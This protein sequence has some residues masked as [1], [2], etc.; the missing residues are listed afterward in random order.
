MWSAFILGLAGSLHC[1]GMCGPL[2]LALPLGQAGKIRS[3]LIYHG[4]RVLTYAAMGLFFGLLGKGLMLAGIQKGLSIGAGILMIA[5]AFTA[6]RLEQ[7]V[8]AL[9]GFARFTRSV[10]HR[11]GTVLREH[12]KGAVLSMGLLNGLLPC[13]M[14]YAALAGAI[15]AGGAREGA[16]YMVLFGAGTTPLLL[17]TTVWGRAFSTDVRRRFRLLQP[18]LMTAAGAILILRGLN[19]DLSLFES[20]VPPADVECH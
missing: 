14:V 1:I 20:A 2:I 9:P 19:L 8:N 12:P 7:L 4:G 5:L 3:W 11:M 15:A 16:F 13:G 18:L 17:A 6:W 10:Q